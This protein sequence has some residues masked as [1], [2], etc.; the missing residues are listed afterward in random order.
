MVMSMGPDTPSRQSAV[1]QCL[2]VGQGLPLSPEGRKAHVTLDP[3]RAN[4]HYSSRRPPPSTTLRPAAGGS[5]THF[6]VL[7][8]KV[9]RYTHTPHHTNRKQPSFMSLRLHS[10]EVLLKGATRK[11]CPSIHFHP[12]IG[13]LLTLS[14]RL[15]P[16]TPRRKV[17][18]VAH[19][20]GQYPELM[21]IGEGW[22]VE[23]PVNQKLRLLA[24]LR[25]HHDGP[26]QRP[27]HCMHQTTDSLS[28]QQWPKAR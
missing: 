7:R 26:T 3:G 23:G 14:L 4:G 22:D 16:A 11:R 19:S 18:A 1:S 2:A 8:V 15:S 13:D 17:I 6:L 24:Q 27:H 25:L 21:T 5:E 10:V 20:F 28:F 12:L 9:P